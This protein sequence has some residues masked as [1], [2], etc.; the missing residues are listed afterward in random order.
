MTTFDADSRGFE[1][2]SLGFHGNQFIQEP[3]PLSLCLLLQ[4]LTPTECFL[5][6]VSF[7][8]LVF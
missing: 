6:F 4:L 7:A 2:K 5:C 3:I 8:S 1:L